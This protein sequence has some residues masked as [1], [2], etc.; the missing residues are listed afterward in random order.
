VS[1]LTG[2]LAG[3]GLVAHEFAEGVIAFSV[4]VKGGLSAQKA[5]FYGFLVAGLTTP[6]GAFVVYPFV[7][8][9]SGSALGLALGFVGGVLIYVSASHLLPE[10][11]EHEKFHSQTAF[12]LG[13]LLAVGLMF[14]E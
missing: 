13:V 11:R 7:K 3:I 6:V 2:V 10:A 1:T 8:N 4:L 12:L 14:L 5:A 9:L